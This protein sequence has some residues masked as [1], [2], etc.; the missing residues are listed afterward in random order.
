MEEFGRLQARGTCSALTKT[1]R[2]VQM[3]YICRPVVPGK[4]NS[5]SAA[6]GGPYAA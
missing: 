5:R 1:T 2:V 4:P 3:D 6:D